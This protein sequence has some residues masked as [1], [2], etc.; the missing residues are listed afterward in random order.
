MI[1]STSCG[2]WGDNCCLGRGGF[3]GIERDGAG[4]RDRK[5]K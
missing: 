2:D 3:L 4:R 1:L 5:G